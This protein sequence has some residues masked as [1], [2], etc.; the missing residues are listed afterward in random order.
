MSKGILLSSVQI[1][2]IEMLDTVKF[3]IGLGLVF[4]LVG[5]CT[6]VLGPL[7][8]KSD[9][10]LQQSIQVIRLCFFSMLN[11]YLCTHV[12]G[13]LIKHEQTM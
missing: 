13:L 5:V 4:G 11:S 10:W 7:N 8:G 1:I 3:S 9:N 12:P 2:V 6:T